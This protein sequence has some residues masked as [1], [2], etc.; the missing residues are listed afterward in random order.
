MD[1]ISPSAPFG[2][3]AGGKRAAVYT[4]NLGEHSRMDMSIDR[5]GCLLCEVN[6]P[7]CRLT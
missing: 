4:R 2:L 3:A 1:T 7:T 5:N 6:G